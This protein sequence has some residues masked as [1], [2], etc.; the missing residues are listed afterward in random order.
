MKKAK[1]V[2]LLA[3][4]FLVLVIVLSACAQQPPTTTG[5]PAATSTP[6]TKTQ[7]VAPTFKVLNPVG[8]YIPVQTAP[9]APRLSSLAGKNIWYYESEAN[10]VIM[11]VLLARLKKDYPTATWKYYETQGWGTDAVTAEE[12][13]GVDAVIRGIGW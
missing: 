11:P 1:F 2:A 8:N 7:V 10:P 12:L 13:K 9:L 3:S 5:G 4:S 6:T